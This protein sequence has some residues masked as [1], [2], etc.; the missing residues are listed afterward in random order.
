MVD[1][2]GLV[3]EGRRL[4]WRNQRAL[5]WLFAA[6]LLL[7]ALGAEPLAV[8]LAGVTDHSMAAQRLSQGFALTTL[9]ELVSRPGFGFSSDALNSI[10]YNVIFF[11]FAVFVTGGILEGFRSS[12]KLSTA[13]FFEACGHYF[14]RWVRQVLLFSAAMALV[15]GVGSGI[16]SW[17]DTL[18]SDAA[19]EKLGF[20][21]MVGGSALT[22]LLAM[23]AR[24]WFDMAQVQIVATDQRSVVRSVGQ[25]FRLMSSNFKTLFF[26][27][28]RISLIGWTALLLGLWV[29]IRFIPATRSML[30]FL[31]L[32]LALL[33]WLATRLWQRA[34]ETAWYQR[35]EAANPPVAPLMMDA[36]LVYPLA[37]PEP[38]GNVLA[39]EDVKQEMP[40]LRLEDSQ[41]S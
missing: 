29:W 16:Y 33:A 34:S 30:S 6:N 21:V 28:L 3:S 5:W 1:G 22:L 32:E 40:V 41:P 14:W 36:P 10:F 19:A 20:W 31:V 23:I 8:K 25:A 17:S 15:L 38:T 4:V 13:Q 2:R 12:R 26:M 35:Y 11:V 7:A 18:S 39:V 37:A 9:V 27:Y 24:L